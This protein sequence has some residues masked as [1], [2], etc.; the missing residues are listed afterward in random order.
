[1]TTHPLARRALEHAGIERR[2][3]R[4]SGTSIK[5]TRSTA[6][7]AGCTLTG[8]ASVANE[9]Y[10]V[11]DS[12]G[13]FTETVRSG[14]FYRTLADGADTVFLLNHEGCALA[15]TRPGTLRLTEDG[16]RATPRGEVRSR[17]PGGS[18]GALCRRA[19]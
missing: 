8:Y 12:L 1:M 18:D 5:E 6:G 11:H 4:F 15:R 13:E 3:R 10:T 16:V 9:P 7:I 19:G 17:Q 14:A 2:S